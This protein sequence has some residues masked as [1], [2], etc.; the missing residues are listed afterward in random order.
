[1]SGRKGR[2]GRPKGFDPIGLAGHH[3]NVLIELWLAGYPIGRRTRFHLVQPQVPRDRVALPD[4]V[5][6][7]IMRVLARM[8]FEQVKD[9]KPNLKWPPLDQETVTKV[10]NRTERRAPDVTLRRQRRKTVTLARAQELWAKRRE[11]LTDSELRELRAVAWG[12]LLAR[13][14]DNSAIERKRKPATLTT[15]KRNAGK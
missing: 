7:R 9:V 2:S 6:L 1:M 10:I 11:D 14:G 5:P 12:N 15:K 13:S 8:A 3:L 4:R